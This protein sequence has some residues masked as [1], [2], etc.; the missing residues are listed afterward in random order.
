MEALNLSIWQHHENK[1]FIWFCFKAH[2]HKVTVQGQAMHITSPT[3][4][5]YHLLNN[6]L[7]SPKTAYNLDTGLDIASSRLVHSRD[8]CFPFE[9]SVFLTLILP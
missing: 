5:S 9:G 4:D 1:R 7:S 6:L 2:K 3:K 8:S